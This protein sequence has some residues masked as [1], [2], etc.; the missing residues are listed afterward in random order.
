M[1]NDFDRVAPIYDRLA[2]LVFGNKL[3]EVQQTFLHVIP[4]SSKVLIVGGG[5]GKIL[6]WLPQEKNL[7]IAYIELS[8]K[9]MKQAK[10]RTNS[11]NEVLF[12]H[13]D[14]MDVYDEFD[15]IIANFFL[16]C[17][18]S[19]GLRKVL[20]KFS[21][22]LAKKGQLIVTD[23]RK[24]QNKRDFW[25]MKLMHAF[26]KFVSNLESNDLLDLHSEILSTGFKEQNFQE[27]DRGQL[28]TAVYS[29][30]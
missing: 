23:F 16:D 27:I 28:F 4:P 22:L 26:F 29:K 24:N 10:G 25:L 12:Y 18:D 3:E 9:M 5:S 7:E 19:Q 17:F 11:S 6:E 20:E 13:A 14:I 15:V 8:K 1:K 30:Y 2:Y 21:L